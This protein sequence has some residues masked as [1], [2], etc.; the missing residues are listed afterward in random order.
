MTNPR[1]SKL[2]QA[3]QNLIDLGGIAE[4]TTIVP[5]AEVINDA[6]TGL[7]A[8]YIIVENELG[9]YVP[10]VLV[11]GLTV[12]NG[13]FVNLLYIKGTEIIA[14]QHGSGSGGASTGGNVW[15]KDG[16]NMLE[17]VNYATV[18]LQIAAMSAGSIGYWGAR[19]SAEA[20][21]V[22]VADITLQGVG[23]LITTFTSPLLV[24]SVTTRTRI[25]DASWVVTG[26]GTAAVRT[27]DGPVDFVDVKAQHTGVEDARG[28]QLEA[29]A[30][31]YD[32]EGIADS[33]GAGTPTA[34]AVYVTNSATVEIHGGN[35]SATTGTADEI[36][37]DAGA[38]VLLDG[39]TLAFG[40]FG[41]VGDI[42]GWYIDSV[43]GV[44]FVSYTGGVL[45]EWQF[46][47]SG[48]LVS[49]ANSKLFLGDGATEA[50]LNVTERAT[51]PSSPNAE[52][53][54][55]DDGSNTASGD[56]G[57]RRYT[58][59]AWEDIG[60]GGGSGGWPFA[61]VLTVSTTDPD[62]DYSTIA[63]AITAA[64]AGDVILLDAETY[65]VAVTLNKNITLKGSAQGD[66]I[67]TQGAA[68]VTLT[69]STAGAVVEDLTVTN[70]FATG[71]VKAISITA[72]C[73]LRNVIAQSTGAATTGEAIFI[74]GA[75]VDLINCEASAT[76]ATTKIGLDVNNSS[77]VNVYGGKYDGTNFDVLIDTSTVNLFTPYLKNSTFLAATS[78]VR[79]WYFDAS[80]HV[81]FEG[82]SVISGLDKASVTKV[83][84]SDGSPDALTTS[85]TGAVTIPVSLALAAGVAV[86][87]IDITAANDD[88]ALITSGGVFDHTNVSD[89]VHG[90]A[91]GEHVLG[92]RGGA[93]HFVQQAAISSTTSGT[94]ALS[95][96]V[97][98]SNV[99]I[100]FPVA[101]GV[102]PIVVT[103]LAAGG[104]MSV[105]SVTTTNFVN[106]KFMTA[107][108]FAAAGSYIAIGS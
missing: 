75:T 66:T 101:F 61:H 103:S 53:I 85:A 45:K 1:V 21:D 72:S 57:F 27:T 107:A 50:P 13:D 65:S 44:H 12:S 71:T 89:G 95:L 78:T 11:A 59:S 9:F 55:L 17:G 77:V 80:G 20:I 32:C 105:T 25:E 51:E 49:T 67:I 68:G 62:A 76:T 41:G 10:A 14:F 93:G 36:F 38:S 70:T 54:Y 26:S 94:S 92:H 29:D 35:F 56:P 100:T 23:R 3:L 88:T 28:F 30:R 18:A 83:K 33:T 40:N 90:L 82:S 74:D 108:S 52:D 73:R 19:T 7:P 34:R 63:A 46:N 97:D 2:E 24:S 37:A 102:A 4:T 69:I 104:V 5:N 8:G 58:G 15:P 81:V 86:D 106:R 79:G 87:D 16:Q 42:N 64:A 60:G 84:A 48:N 22:N 91:A 98:P 96:F 47:S 99:T 6:P 31:L 39:P 43:G